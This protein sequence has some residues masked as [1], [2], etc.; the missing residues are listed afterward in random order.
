MRIIVPVSFALLLLL[1]GTATAG[2]IPAFCN[3]MEMG[4]SF[5]GKALSMTTITGDQY[6]GS[7]L[8]RPQTTTYSA[9]IAGI[10]TATS[11]M[12][13]TMNGA[14]SSISFSQQTTASGTIMKYFAEYHWSSGG[15]C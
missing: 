13:G 1:M 3:I 5:S 12:R 11:F 9:D 7:S 2:S 14:S 6:V 10:G 8:F 4:S 15:S